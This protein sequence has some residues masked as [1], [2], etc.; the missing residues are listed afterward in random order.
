MNKSVAT[1]P[2]P[3]PPRVSVVILNYNGAQWIE[4]CLASLQ[5]QTILA[6]TE[7]I[8][9]DNLSTDGSDKLA[10]K[11]VQTQQNA[12]FIQH[13]QN[14][15]YC[16]G[17]NRAAIAATG[18]FLFF[19]NND[20][21][22]E[23][24]CL[25]RLLAEVEAKGA[26]AATPMVMDF[27]DDNFQ[28]MGAEGLDLCGLT[29]TRRRYNKTREVFMP[30]GCSYLIERELFERVGRFD[31]RLFMYSDELDLSWRVWISG[32]TALAV[33]AARLHHRGAANVNPQGGGQ[34][35]EFRTSDSKRFYANRNGLLVVLKNAQNLLLLQIPLQL[36]M[37]ALEALVG[38]VLIRR[39]R[40]VKRAYLDAVIE[41]WRMRDHLATERR[42]VRGFRRRGD[43]WMLRFL[44][45]RF[46][47]WDEIQRARLLGLPKVSAR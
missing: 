35:V 37:L 44:R 25:E 28:S 6:D 5:T 27:S 31:A 19:L 40:F 36:A 41:C 12:R 11:L 1:L 17:N 47:R 7:I 34:V 18:K 32:R 3:R 21:W 20:A 30:E 16:E 38:L 43:F 2:H 22:L 14:L 39:W 42:R 46:N 9:A 10:E 26:G 45:L 33:P 8:V 4:R 29:S 13:G 24:D 23:P 15:G